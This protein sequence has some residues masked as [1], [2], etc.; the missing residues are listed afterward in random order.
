M[1]NKTVRPVLYANTVTAA[2]PLKG[3]L[4]HILEDGL[5]EYQC[6]IMRVR[7]DEVLVRYFSAWDGEPTTEA[8]Y[9]LAFI[10][11]AQCRLYHRRDMQLWR[12]HHY[13][14]FE[15]AMR[16]NRNLPGGTTDAR[17]FGLVPRDGGAS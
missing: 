16:R 13:R 3:M 15:E 6:E 2:P 10:N 14:D 1:K 11:S 8:W 7:G 5:A 17:G 12:D 4:V 9:P